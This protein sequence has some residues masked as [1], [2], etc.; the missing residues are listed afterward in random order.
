MTC[1][2]R[3]SSIASWIVG[4]AHQPL[5]RA[6]QVRP[7]DLRRQLLAAEHLAQQ[8]IDDEAQLLGQRGEIGHGRRCQCPR[9]AERSRRPARSIAAP[10]I[11]GPVMARWP[12]RPTPRLPIC[13]IL[14]DV[15]AT[16]RRF[17]WKQGLVHA[18]IPLAFVLLVGGVLSGLGRIADPFGFGQAL[19]RS[20]VILMLAA[21]GISYLAQ[22]GHERLA[23]GLALALTLLLV[24]ATI[25][26]LVVLLAM[27]RAGATGL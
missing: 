12:R 2:A 23:R 3:A 8:T 17:S 22:T 1:R 11:A 27:Q 5:E 15:T 20:S 21:L 19:G 18:L 25:A 13:R 24:G 26:G 14:A 16:P 10:A 9:R 6:D 4:D 7:V